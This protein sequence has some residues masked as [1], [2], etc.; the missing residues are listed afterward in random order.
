MEAPAVIRDTIAKR[1][2]IVDPFQI[3]Q[4]VEVEQFSSV[5]SFNISDIKSVAKKHGVSFNAV[6]ISVYGR[7]IGKYLSSKHGTLLDILIVGS[8][9]PWPGRP[10]NFIGNHHNL[11][12]SAVPLKI[13]SPIESLDPV[14]AQITDFYTS[15][16]CIINKYIVL[17]MQSIFPSV[18]LGSVITASGARCVL[19]PMLG[20]DEYV[21]NGRSV[22]SSTPLAGIGA[23]I[24]GM[25]I[26]KEVCSLLT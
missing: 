1:K 26:C 24:V 9:T 17:K 25:Y 4:G 3:A 15:R 22:R 19:S 10:E 18:I 11:M 21:Y 8:A 2:T 20:H 23:S 14:Q 7:A 6:L 5:L 12:G 16:K 13:T